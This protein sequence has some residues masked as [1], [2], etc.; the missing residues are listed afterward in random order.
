M[1]TKKIILLFAVLFL[2][3]LINQAQI[4]NGSKSVT[5]KVK[6]ITH[7]PVGWGDLF[8]GTIEEVIEGNKRDM[9]DTI[10]FGLSSNPYYDF[11]SVGGIRIITFNNSGKIHE[12]NDYY[13][14]DRTISKRNEIWVITK[15]IKPD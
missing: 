7:V 3:P 11:L 5:L 9:P 1:T 15:I 6:I 8:T 12:K 10:T 14:G 13:L 2:L 4:T